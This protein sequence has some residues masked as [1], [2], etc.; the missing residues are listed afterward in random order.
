M[1]DALALAA[2][3]VAVFIAIGST[4]Y[5]Y[6]M[7]PR[8]WRWLVVVGALALVSWGFLRRLG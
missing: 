6:R 7:V 4:V 2:K 8:G 1:I 3:V 5:V